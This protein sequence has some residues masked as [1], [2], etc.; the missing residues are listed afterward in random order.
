[1]MI[2]PVADHY[3]VRPDP[4]TVTPVRIDLS[5][6]GPFVIVMR[7]DTTYFS[8]ELG[9]RLTVTRSGTHPLSGPATELAESYR[10]F[11]RDIREAFRRTWRRPG[12]IEFHLLDARRLELAVRRRVGDSPLISLDPLITRGVSPLEVSRGYLLGGR[13][14]VGLVPRPGAAPISTQLEALRGY[15][16]TGC[17]LIEDD[18]CTGETIATVVRLLRG[19]GI[20][21]SRVVPGIRLD[22]GALPGLAGTAVEP[23]L[24][25]RTAGGGVGGA[26]VDAGNSAAVE[27]TDPRNYLFGLSGLAVR[28]PGGGW[29]RAPYWLPFVRTSVRVGIPAETEQEFALLAL[30]ANL[31]FFTRAERLL[32]RTLRVV[33]LLPPVRELIQALD[34]ASPLE[35]VR[36]VLED[37]ITGMD[38]WI[39]LIAAIEESDTAARATESDAAT[40]PTAGARP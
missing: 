38:R 21:V 40:R 30:E 17:T 34:L 9:R 27:L 19:A 26:H 6:A 18:M 35:P 39:E 22:G 33:D 20:P 2:A 8:S 23:V 37:L 1:M 28:L 24:Q 13:T 29:G 7:D 12:G 32:R 4:M 3:T 16:A 25:Y 11:Q 36:R 14:T 5:V 10:G 31:R 15:A